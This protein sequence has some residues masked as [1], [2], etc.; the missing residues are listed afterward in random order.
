MAA[1]VNEERDRALFYEERDRQLAAMDARHAVEEE[2]DR[3][4]MAE[5]EQQVMLAKAATRRHKFQ[6]QQVSD[7][8]E[9]E[10]QQWE[11]ASEIGHLSESPDTAGRS[12]EMVGPV[13]RH[14][15]TGIGMLRA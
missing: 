9:T 14:A 12:L 3:L 7:R 15:G 13:Q 6:V 2:Q 10:S 4:E 5:L 11:T 8:E 1:V